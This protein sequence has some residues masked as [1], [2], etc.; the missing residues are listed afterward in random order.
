MSAI[1]AKPGANAGSFQ[2]VPSVIAII[3]AI[4]LVGV[5][6]FLGSSGILAGGAMYVLQT[7]SLIILGAALIAFG[8]HFVPVG[9][10]PAA[11]GQAPGIATGVAMLATG[12]GLAGLFGG[13]WAAELGLG[14]AL[15]SGA[16]GGAL[17]MAITC[18]MVNISYVFGMGI[19]AASGKVLK[20]PIT[21]DLQAAYKSQGTEG[22]GLPFIS[23]V[24]G[25]IG[26]LFGGLGGTLIYVELLN[27]YNAGLPALGFVGA[28]DINMLSVGLAGIF[29]IGMFL[30]IAV[31]SA[32]NITGTIE[33]PHDP[34]FKRFPR[35]IVAA[36]LAS[37]VCGLVAMLVV[38]LF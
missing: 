29:A 23:Y 28:E 3:I 31:L 22:H 10:A 26:G 34:K 30:V 18:L 36:I 12:A 32:Y 4:V 2:P 15:A 5:A 20:D 19:P 6:Y 35:A 13:A 37:S 14:V 7:L 25:V 27:F 8:V 1:A 24:G 16:I 17:M 11:M 38:A 21:G 9:G 33:G